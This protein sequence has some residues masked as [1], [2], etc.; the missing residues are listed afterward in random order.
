MQNY[1]ETMMREVE[2][3]I[4]TVDLHGEHIIEDCKLII[5]C[6]KEKLAELRIFV[7]NH[8]FPNESAEIAFFKHHK[9]A[10]LGRLLYFHEVLCIEMRRPFDDKMLDEYYMRCQEEQKLFFDRHVSFY[11]YYR[12]GVNNLDHYYFMRGQ[13]EEGFDVDV[14]HFDDGSGFSTGYDHL[15][16]RIM[17]MEMLYAHLTEKR[18]ICLQ[19]DEEEPTDL[20]KIKGAYKWT[21]NAIELVEMV[22]GLNEMGCLN[23]G[24][25]PIHELAAF[26]G[27]LF[28]IDVRDCYSAYTDM[29]RRKNESRTYF[30]DKMRER[31]NKRMQQDDERERKR[32]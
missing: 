13:Q 31:L 3:H 27:A 16:A 6:L 26:M 23:E 18:R 32:K 29:K 8:T 14:C 10:L 24:E 12:S 25:A 21:G 7:E 9:P 5:V 11:Q 20:L 2:G 22:Y 17:A 28:G 1:Y 19:K 4:S 15:V 30:L